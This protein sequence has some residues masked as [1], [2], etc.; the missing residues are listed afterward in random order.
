MNAFSS[1]TPAHDFQ[2]ADAAVAVTPDTTGGAVTWTPHL[3]NAKTTV[4]D[5]DVATGLRITPTTATNWHGTKTAPSV[6][7]AISNL[8]PGVARTDTVCLQVNMSSSPDVTANY[9]MFGLGITASAAFDTENFATNHRAYINAKV[10]ITKQNTTE[11]TTATATQHDFREI[12]LYPGGGMTLNSGV[13][14]GAFPEPN[15]ITT[16]Q[17]VLAPDQTK[18]VTQA[19]FDATDA[20]IH[21]FSAKNASVTAITSTV[22]AF[23]AGTLDA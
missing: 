17:K 14:T 19:R 8:I 12:I 22:V 11:Y 2:A 1:H 7:A 16:W 5:L 3:A 21:F 23:R 4:C 9:D 6:W 13:W 10:E 15:A 20:Y 18:S